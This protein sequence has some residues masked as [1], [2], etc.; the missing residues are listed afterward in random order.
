MKNEELSKNNSCLLKELEKKKLEL[1]ILQKEKQDYIEEQNV[2]LKNIMMELEVEKQNANN[3]EKRFIE[4]NNNLGFTLKKSQD[5]IQKLL[6]EKKD[7]SISLKS[8]EK[9]LADIVGLGE[10]ET[11]DFTISLNKLKKDLEH[12]RKISSEVMDLRSYRDSLQSQLSQEKI[13]LESCKNSLLQLQIRDHKLMSEISEL[14]NQN[15]ELEKRLKEVDESWLLVVE[16]LEK[17]RKKDKYRLKE[18]G[19]IVS[20][21]DNES[22]NER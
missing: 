17:K 12:Y 14:K 4:E 16:E 7:I 21:T 18:L 20:E 11:E 2:K 1:H 9:Q 5:E 3:M 8:I 10:N 15:S 22:E 19:D 13:S 6:H